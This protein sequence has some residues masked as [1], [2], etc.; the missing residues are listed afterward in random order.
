MSALPR[1]ARNA[2]DDVFV[3]VG[4]GEMF[5]GDVVRAIHPDFKEERASGPTPAKSESGWFGLNKVANL[6]FKVPGQA[7]AEASIPIRGARGDLPV[8]FA[9]RAAPC[10]ANAS[11]AS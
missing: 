9:P 1:L 4:R 11:S 3:A 5:S 8:R 6:M 2:L 7:D 10:R